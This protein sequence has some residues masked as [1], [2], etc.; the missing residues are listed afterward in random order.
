MEMNLD[1]IYYNFILDGSKIYET[2]I[3]D[4][5]R[6]KIKLL[7]IIEFKE[8]NSTNSFK[9]QIIELSYFDTF[10]DALVSAGLRKVL[11]NARSLE[12]GIGLYEQFPHKK[13]GNYKK[14]AKEYGVLRMKFKLI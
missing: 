8:R 10:R 14:A 6:Q 13:Y 9:G 11:P 2:R 1:S 5:K 7:D 4:E 12:D 3:F